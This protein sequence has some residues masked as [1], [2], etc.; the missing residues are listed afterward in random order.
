MA[1]IALVLALLTE[2]YDL[3]AEGVDEDEV[4]RLLEAL[5]ADLT[6][7][8]GRAPKGKLRIEIYRTR[9]DWATALRRDR[10][11]VPDGAGGYYAPGTKTAYLYVQPSEY[12]T[13]QL[14]LHEA[15]HQFHYLAATGNRN[16][17]VGW[18]TE[19]LAEYFAMHN[20]DG[21]KL[22]TGVVPAVTLEDYPAKALEQFDA[23]GQDFPGLVGGEAERLAE[24]AKAFRAWIVEH[25]QP[26]KIVWVAWQERGDRIEGA[27]NV[28]GIA[29][30]KKPAERLEAEIDGDALAGLVFGFRSAD[31][32]TLFQRT[33]GGWRVVRR[34][35]GAWETLGSGAKSGRVLAVTRK[36]EC[37][38]DG[39]RVGTF[40]TSGDLG[41]NVDGG[42][43]RFKVAK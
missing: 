32:F 41:L 30:L 37:F 13:R 24:F 23:R 27:S 36:G 15:T 25:Q 21:T 26:W 12:F 6:K 43:A 34:K 20:W 2:H 38:V 7:H 28:N 18:Y 17:A 40:E 11:I 10:Q 35:N 1:G 16:P 31:E 9:D 14:I 29:L 33:S 42:R 4:G 5:H 3:H 8:F 22:Q 19:G 39:E